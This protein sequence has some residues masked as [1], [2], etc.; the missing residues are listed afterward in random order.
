[1]RT[2]LTIDDSLLQRAKEESAND[3]RPLAA[4]SLKYQAFREGDLAEGSICHPSLAIV[5]CH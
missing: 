4:Y 1:M 5:S 2:T 3:S